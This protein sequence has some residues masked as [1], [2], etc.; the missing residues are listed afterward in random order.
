MRDVF[1]FKAFNECV[2][3]VAAKGEVIDGTGLG[4]HVVAGNNQMDKRLITPI[5]PVAGEGERRSFAHLEAEDSTKKSLV[6]SR[7]VVEMLTCSS[8]MP[9]TL[10]GLFCRR[11]NNR[12]G[13]CPSNHNS[14]CQGLASL[15]VAGYRA[16][17]N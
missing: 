12:T 10:Q 5:E 6:A 16:N 13:F 3:V 17:Q 9:A 4:V 15:S 11:E 14:V 7:S 1:R 2:H 8:R